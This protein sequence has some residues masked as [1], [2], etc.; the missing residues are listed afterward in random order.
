MLIISILATD[1][2][3]RG[4]TLMTLANL[5]HMPAGTEKMQVVPSLFCKCMDVHKNHTTSHEDAAGS[6]NQIADSEA[7]PQSN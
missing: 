3:E 4:G 5:A 2:I 1:L 6:Q 7:A